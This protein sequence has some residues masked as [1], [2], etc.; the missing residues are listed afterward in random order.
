MLMGMLDSGTMWKKPPVPDHLISFNNKSLHRVFLALVCLRQSPTHLSLRL[1]LQL[2]ES[3]PYPDPNKPL[4][5]PL[6]TRQ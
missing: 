5:R 4:S 1:L 3:W 2:D 6:R